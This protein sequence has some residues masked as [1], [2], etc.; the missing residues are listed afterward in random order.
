[1][2]LGDGFPD[3]KGFAVYSCHGS[4]SDTPVGMKSLV[5]RVTTVNPW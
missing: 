2:R 4:S 5:L 3:S 1:M